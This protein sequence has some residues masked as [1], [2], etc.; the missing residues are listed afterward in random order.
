MFC[1]PNTDSTISRARIDKYYLGSYLK[2]YK[3]IAICPFKPTVKKYV[4]MVAIS[5]ATYLFINTYD[6]KIQSFSQEHRSSFTNKLSKDVFEPIGSGLYLFP[7]VALI[8]THGLIFNNQK[9]K[10][11]G[12]N[13]VK[14]FILASTFAQISKYSFQRQRPNVNPPDANNW[15]TGNR[16]KSFFSGHTTTAFSIA[17]VIAE[18]YRKTIWVPILCYTA[19]S[20]VGLSR[21]NDNK[22]WA[23]DVFVGALT[24][25]LVGRLVVH[26]NNWGIQIV[27]RLII[28]P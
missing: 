14:S 16:D 6:E 12:M 25:Y 26:T 24:G 20:G 15:F 21:I 27:P 17:T 11:V 8:Y 22:H 2:D 3:S 5:G 18:E 19:A 28:E 13:C 10:K 4:A 23:S 1:Q 9:S 7:A